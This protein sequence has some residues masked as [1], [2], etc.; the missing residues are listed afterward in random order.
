MQIRKPVA[1]MLSIVFSLHAQTDTIAIRELALATQI[2]STVEVRLAGKEQPNRLR[3]QMGLLDNESF[4]LAIGNSG[5][6]PRKVPFD[7]VTSLRLIKKLQAKPVEQTSTP[8][9][10]A[11]ALPK[12]ALVELR[13]A[14]RQTP[15]S[16]RGRIVQAGDQ[17]FQI[18]VFRSGRIEIET[19]RFAEVE[20]VKPVD[21]LWVS[22]APA[23]V[24]RAIGTG[25]SIALTAVLV[26]VIVL[27]VAAKT[28][29][30]GG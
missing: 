1:A 4:D 28:G 26:V 10:T 7:R 19:L 15:G 8:Q 14:G 22:S 24:H 2:G 13:F 6:E 25:V 20:S 27:V 12:G 9:A 5:S 21:S 23:K 18:Q 3:G 17:E 29:H 16:L 11:R 30:L